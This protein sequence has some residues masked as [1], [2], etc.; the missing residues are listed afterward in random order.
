MTTSSISG[1][2]GTNSS[3][4]TVSAAKA[5][6][7][8]FGDADFLTIML[9]EITNQDPMAPSDTSKMVESMRQLQV[10]ANTANEKFR[11]DVTWAQQMSGSMVNVNQ[12]G[13]TEKEKTAYIN[14]GLV[15]DVGYANKD[16][17]VVGFR[18][19]DQTVWVQ[20]DNGKDYPVDNIKQV[21]NNQFDTNALV[22]T[23]SRLL[24]MR[25]GYLSGIDKTRTEGVVS[26]VGYD[27]LGK[28]VL[29]VNKG[30]VNYDDVVSITVPGTTTP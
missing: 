7:Q 12:V 18:V 13:A 6:Q 24:G 25:V 27:S 10:L 11:A 8:A 16:I 3:S 1:L 2:N 17:R 26:S 14:A 21:R 20:G 9:T 15:P 28:V 30:Y 5:N 19:V 23:S 4:G 29:G 22:E